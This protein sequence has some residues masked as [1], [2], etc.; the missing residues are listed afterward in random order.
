[1]TN[2]KGFNKNFNIYTIIKFCPK[3]RSLSNNPL[4]LSKNL[5]LR[6]M[7]SV[8][9]MTDLCIFCKMVALF[10]PTGSF[11]AWLTSAEYP[12]RT[13]TWCYTVSLGSQGFS[14]SIPT[15]VDHISVSFPSL[16]LGRYPPKDSLFQW[17]TLISALCRLF[18]SGVDSVGPHVNA[19]CINHFIP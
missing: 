9:D 6:A 7:F 10:S 3:K 19:V 13:S 4:C 16:P 11:T 17:L 15:L 14:R 1:M 12:P 8:L 2:A 5:K 18:N